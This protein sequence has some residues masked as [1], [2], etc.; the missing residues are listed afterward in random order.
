M[1]R[2]GDREDCD[3]FFALPLNESKDKINPN[4]A[5]V[6]SKM[7]S[8]DYKFTESAAKYI[9]SNI[10]LVYYSG[11]ASKSGAADGDNTPAKAS[12]TKKRKAA[13]DHTLSSVEGLL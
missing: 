1:P 13:D 4:C 6:M 5:A 11:I 3:L 8:W 2:W 7:D 12:A 10:Y 9:I